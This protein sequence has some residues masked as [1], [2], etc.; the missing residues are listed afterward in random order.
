MNQVD[1]K[2]R[3]PYTTGS[4]CVELEVH[5]RTYHSRETLCQCTPI[6]SITCYAVPAG[7][8]APSDCKT[9]IQSC[10]FTTRHSCAALMGGGDACLDCG[11]RL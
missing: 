5:H 4:M 3:Q 2:P 10:A 11:G 6:T 7:A 1:P 8:L 9:H